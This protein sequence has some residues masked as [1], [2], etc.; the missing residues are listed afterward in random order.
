MKDSEPDCLEAQ[1]ALSQAPPRAPVMF[2]SWRSLLFLHWRWDPAEIQATLPQG[3]TVHTFEGDA[4][5]GVVPFLMRNVRPRF[6][7]TVP[8]LSNFL[9]LNLRTYVYDAQGQPGVWFYSLDAN[10]WLAVKIARTLF[11][12]PYFHA[13]MTAQTR[14]SGDLDFLSKRAGDSE[15]GRFV[16]RGEGEAFSAEPGTLE[17]FLV[18]RYLLFT[19]RARDGAIFTGR[20]HHQPYPLQLANPSELSLR[21]FPL[22]NF[23]QP[24]RPADHQIF[25]PG[26]DV[27]IYWFERVV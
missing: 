12:L 7:P 15:S 24:G 6:C 25:S 16:Y 2:Q 8:G 14:T 13:T 11:R 21:L 1:I 10:Q 4:Y 27:D 22:S 5:L 23:P 18:E 3:L 9:E 17:Y 19:T 26:V 20:V